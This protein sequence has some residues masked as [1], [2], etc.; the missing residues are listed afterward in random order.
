MINTITSSPQGRGA[1]IL[2]YNMLTPIR[3]W[4]FDAIIHLLPCKGV[5]ILCYNIIT[6]RGRN[7]IVG[8]NISQLYFNPG[9]VILRG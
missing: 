9:M 4:K 2:C 6:P 3:R 5:K 8:V 1:Y 7:F